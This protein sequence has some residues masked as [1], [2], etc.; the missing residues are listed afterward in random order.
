MKQKEAASAELTFSRLIQ[1]KTKYQ[2]IIPNDATLNGNN[3][4]LSSYKP[5]E[6]TK[7]REHSV[8]Q[9]GKL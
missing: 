4:L 9:H 2:Q 5:K 6:S 7:I 8:Y 3:W 1:L